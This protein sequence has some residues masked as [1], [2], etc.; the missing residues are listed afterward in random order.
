MKHFIKINKPKN[1]NFKASKITQ[2]IIESKFILPTVEVISSLKCRR[3][4][5]VSANF[6]LKLPIHPHHQLRCKL[7]Q[8]FFDRKN[9]HFFLFLLPIVYK[10]LL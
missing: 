10:K 8:L 1:H 7:Q 4:F 9:V 5:Q 2:L 6:R 3:T